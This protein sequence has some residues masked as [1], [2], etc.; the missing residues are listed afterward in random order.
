[1]NDMSEVRIREMAQASL[2][3][4]V[5]VD[6]DEGMAEL[7]ERTPMDARVSWIAAGRIGAFVAADEDDA[8]DAAR[9]LAAANIDATAVVTSRER[10]PHEARYTWPLFDDAL[11]M[12]D[13]LA[14]DDGASIEVRCP[15]PDEAALAAQLAEATGLPLSRFSVRATS[16]GGDATIPALAAVM[17]LHR[18]G[19]AVR[20]RGVMNA[21][22]TKDARLSLGASLDADAHLNEWRY[23]AD[24]GRRLN[25]TSRLDTHNPYA[26]RNETLRADAGYGAIPNTAHTFARESFVDEIARERDIDPLKFRLTHLDP[27]DDAGARELIDTIADRA[28]WN[29]NPKRAKDDKRMRGRGFAFDKRDDSASMPEYSAWIVDLDVNRAT[30]DVTIERVV[31]GS[32]QGR[33]SIGRIAG[34]PSSRIAAAA[35]KLIGVPLG[36][37][38]AHDETP[39]AQAIAHRIETAS[40]EAVPAT[41][42]D[43]LIDTSPAAAAIANA[44]YDATGVRFRSPPFTPERVRE[45]LNGASAQGKALPQRLRRSLRGA[46]AATGLGGLVALACTAWP[47]RGPIAPIDRPDASTWSQATIARGREVAAVG[48]CAVCHTAPGGAVN[49]GGL[50]LETP[51][52]TVYTTNITPDEQTGIGNW[53]FAAFDRAMR[54]GISRDGHH[55][56]PA[57]PYTSFAKLSDA[58]MT[59][60]YAYL[61]SRPAVASMPPQTRLPFPLNQRGLVAGWNAL[62][63]KQGEYVPDPAR[64]ALWNRGKYLVDGAGHCGACHS[65]R[66][67][68]GAEKGG[69]LYLTG[70]TA[71]GWIAPSLVANSKLPV[72]WSEQALFDYLRTGFSHEHGVAAGPMAPVVSHLSTL[73]A[74]DVRAMAHYVAS[75]STVDADARSP[76]QHDAMRV[77]G[78]ENGRRIFDA[79]CA[80]CHAQSGGVGNFGVRPLLA[81]NTSVNDESPENLLHVILHGIDA[82]ATEELGY[83]PGFKDSFDDRQVAELAAYIR[84]EFAP[85]EG[86]WTGLERASA[87]V[88]R[89]GD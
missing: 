7:A 20:V 21:R 43:P 65:P 59:A 37:Q 26:T 52:G 39:G 41:R 87:K 83:M 4:C 82:P 12:C 61:M 1:M 16:Q 11:R 73:P 3:A 8:F 30:G 23:D 2:A 84:A 56:Y 24:T 46:L 85:R 49:A 13:V 34:V 64:S 18:T 36:A 68:I 42:E 17:L 40:H 5:I 88:R 79:A 29:A 86:P 70:G 69:R 19:R 76:V 51:F 45:A 53:S 50:A 58:D 66:N 38:A 77:H 75:L 60:L 78:F 72:R 35:S 47:L 74:E 28:V 57:F 25:A 6:I 71:E 33:R 10:L 22:E 63:L 9:R 55:L 27:V 89:L 80:V 48:D 81:L 62:Y 15:V 44:L 54:R 14:R 67:A 32:A 31:A